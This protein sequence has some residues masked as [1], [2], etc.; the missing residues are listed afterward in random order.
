M[1][2][3]YL[4]LF[5]SFDLVNSTEYKSKNTNDDWIKIFK[6]FY[7]TTKFFFG[8][9]FNNILPI[10]WKY[11]GDE[12]LFY[13]RVTDIDEVYN[14]LDK[15]VNTI[16]HIKEE[17]SELNNQT[18]PKLSVKSTVWIANCVP[19][20]EDKNVNNEN[21][22]FE[23]IFVDENGNENKDF[24]GSYIDIG[25]RIS[26][27]VTS[28]N[29][30]VSAELAYLLSII[31]PPKN[32]KDIRNKLKIV[33]FEILKGVWDKRAYPIIW[34]SNDWEETKNK[35]P[36]DEFMHSDIIRNINEDKIKP[37]EYLYNVIDELDKK[38]E[39]Y[40][41][42]GLLDNI[43]NGHIIEK[44]SRSYHSKVEMH[45]VAIVIN[46]NGKILIAKRSKN[47][48]FLPDIWEFG[49]SQLEN[50]KYFYDVIYSTYLDEFNIKIS[51]LDE[52]NPIGTYKFSSNGIKKQ[53]II[54]YA[55]TECNEN[56]CK[57]IDLKH[58]EYK[59]IT[60]NEISDIEDN[61]IVENGKY[62]I[63]K[64]FEKYKSRQI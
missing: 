17:L 7:D 14:S 24:L 19:Y 52:N 30:V 64:V 32:S 37:I 36:Y 38:D 31:S 55:E 46:K 63:K 25:F 23:F 60:E 40:H 5:V 2:N 48:N 44:V 1:N 12:I 16:N 42:K 58:S 33:S 21:K 45:C 47:K 13:M 29:I 39:I 41:L 54:F 43:K 59:W 27:Y 6:N 51:Y 26:K 18:T 8:K 22:N 50:N 34:Y 10:L 53:G 20:I 3:E 11:V 49:C 57:L 56:D 15:V 4:Y 9:Q 61:E 28:G 35:F 62:N